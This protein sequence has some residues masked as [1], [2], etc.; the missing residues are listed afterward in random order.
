MMNRHG[1]MSRLGTL[2][3]DTRGVAAV[4]FA[5]LAP[6]LILFYFSMV[7]F[8]QGYMALKRTEHTAAMVA[9]LVSQTDALK[10]QQAVEILDIGD[11]I[12]APFS[13][14]NLKQRV[15]S[16]TR[17][18]TTTYRVD[19]SVGKAMPDKLTVA[20]AKIPSDM[21]AVGESVIVAEAFYDYKSPFD[22]VAPYVTKFNRMAYLRPRTVDFIACAGC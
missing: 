2:A 18:D 6:I 13:T 4:E 9:D 16:V 21:L 20:E 19:W 15:S 7:E 11:L 12:M 17:V 10:K 8:C 14:S 3:R 5:F 1:W 22:R